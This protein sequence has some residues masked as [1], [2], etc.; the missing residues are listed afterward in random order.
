MQQIAPELVPQPSSAAIWMPKK[1]PWAPPDLTDDVVWA[2][3][4]FSKGAAGE[5]QQRVVWNYL[6]Y[7]TGASEQ[8]ADLSFR[9]GMEGMRATDF[10]EGKRFIGLQLRKPLHPALTPNGKVET[11]EETANPAKS[12]RASRAPRSPTRKRGGKRG[13]RK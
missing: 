2:I 7:L 11:D 4:A 1:D 12:A 8:F 3:R 9:P 5:G 6:M 10:A 13:K